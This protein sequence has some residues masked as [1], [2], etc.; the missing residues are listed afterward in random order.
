MSKEKQPQIVVI[1]GGSSGI[2]KDLVAL[3]TQSGDTVVSLSRSN[4]DNF[5]GHITCDVSNKESIEEAA[6][7]INEKYGRVDI[8]I[9]NA[10]L[11]ISGATECLPDEE[12]IKVM[13][14]DFL[15]ALRLAREVLKIMPKTGKIVNI[16]SACALFALPYRGIYCSA[17]AAMSM[18]SYSMRME[19]KRFGIKVITICPGDV[20][21]E[22]TANRIK[23][24]ATN[25]KYGNSPEKSAEAIDKNNDKRMKSEKVAKK[26]YKIA[27]RR[28][29]TLYIIG[30]KY[31]IFFVLQKMLPVGMFNGIVNRIF[32]KKPS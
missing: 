8:L 20:R 15:G 7:Q 27:K 22:F 31:K 1:S 16:S 17:K 25:E 4:P 30:G 13:D 29:G 11:G 2:G 32:N 23:E 5:E 6:A 12:V 28:S 26:I 14:T 18:M 19:L 10:G 21:T 9:N 24:S 3:F